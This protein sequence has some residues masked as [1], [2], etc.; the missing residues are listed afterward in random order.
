M[1]YTSAEMGSA[2]KDWS[3]LRRTTLGSLTVPTRIPNVWDKWA[4][5]EIAK[6]ESAICLN[7][8]QFGILSRVVGSKSPSE[9]V[10]FYY[11]WKSSK[12]YSLWKASFREPEKLRD[13]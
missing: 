10:E 3:L 2:S 1:Y 12:N 8:K 6:F 9:C 7:G 13:A 4:P 11:A 5:L